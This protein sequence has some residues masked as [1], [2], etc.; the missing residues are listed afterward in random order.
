MEPTDPANETTFTVEE[1]AKHNTDTDCWMHIYDQVYDVSPFVKEHPGGKVLLGF[2]GGDATYPFMMTHKSGLS[3]ATL[4][5]YRIGSVSN[6][7]M[8]PVAEGIKKMTEDFRK[9]GYF[10]Y[11]T[12]FIFFEIF[13]AVFFSSIGYY[14]YTHSSSLYGYALAAI[15]VSIG[16]GQTSWWM[17]D[18]GHFSVFK[19][20]KYNRL[21]QYLVMNVYLGGSYTYWRNAHWKHH[22]FTNVEGWDHDLDTLPLFSWTSK[23][24]S[25]MPSISLGKLQ[26]YYWYI[27][28]PTTSF[29]Y[30][31]YLG[32]NFYLKRKYYLVELL[33][34]LVHFAYLYLLLGTIYETIIVHFTIYLLLGIYMGHIFSLNHF[35]MAIEDKSGKKA[36]TG[37]ELSG[38]M[39]NDMVIHQ[40]RTTRNITPSPFVDWFT[41][42][43]N[44]QI[45]HHVWPMMP[46]HNLH[47]VQ[48]VFEEFCKVH[49]IPYQTVGFFEAFVDV[50]NT[51]SSAHS[52]PK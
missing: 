3:F 17:H 23:M 34:N 2:A 15:I 48:P 49:N 31:Y 42:H 14:V 16:K 9:K 35:P 38:I 46:R 13:Q 51:L 44:Y 12:K 43:L 29:W 26:Q 30:I 18:L 45:E 27:L 50:F 28:G 10:N 1:I 21:V 24:F 11:S 39:H 40:L 25:R 32:I 19:E 37:S 22:L 8:T 5:K 52:G 4:K 20:M 41:G 47:K 33:G 36:P 6:Y 7:K